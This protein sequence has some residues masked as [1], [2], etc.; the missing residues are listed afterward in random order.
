MGAISIRSDD[1]RNKN[2]WTMYLHNDTLGNSSIVRYSYSFTPTAV[3]SI[4]WKFYLGSST[5][6]AFVLVSSTSYTGAGA[7]PNPGSTW[8]C[9]QGAATDNNWLYNTETNSSRTDSTTLADSG[10]WHKAEILYNGINTSFYVDNAKIGTCTGTITAGTYYANVFIGAEN[11][12][13][14]LVITLI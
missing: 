12:I 5:T 8:I 4:R 14:E 11:R 2:N 13:K 6:Y 10:A 9:G 7:P 1:V 3:F